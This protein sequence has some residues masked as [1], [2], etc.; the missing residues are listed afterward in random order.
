MD[1]QFVAADAALGEKSALA[2][3]VFEG[4]A[5]SAQGGAFA[6]AVAGSRFTGA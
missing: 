1:I 6:K 2:I 3:V 4:E 5:A